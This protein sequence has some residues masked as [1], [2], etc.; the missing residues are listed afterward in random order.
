MSCS[1]VRYFA[2]ITPLFFSAVYPGIPANAPSFAN[3]HLRYTINWPSGLSLGESQLQAAQINAR[4]DGPARLAFDF[5]L[6]AGIP[7][8]QVD[9]VYHSAAS[10]D[11]CSVEFDKKYYT[12]RRRATRPPGLIWR[13]RQPHARRPEGDNPN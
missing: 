12:E 7:G 1:L 10:A 11:L 4:G 2:L 8:F 6:D 13:A 9:D 5:N 3:E